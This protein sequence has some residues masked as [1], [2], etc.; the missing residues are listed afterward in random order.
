V[1]LAS[2]QHAARARAAVN[3][4]AVVTLED[5]AVEAA[6][7]A[8]PACPARHEDLALILYTSGRRRAPRG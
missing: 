4:V 1:V 5:A 7:A 2:R 3:G 6:G 8:L